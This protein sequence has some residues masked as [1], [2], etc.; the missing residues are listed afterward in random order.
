[1]R[2]KRACPVLRGPRRS[3]TLGLPGELVG[4]FKDAGEAW[5]R[6]PMVV[7]IHDFP[8]DADGRAVP[9][10]VYDVTTNHGLIYLGTSGDTAAFAAD[11]VATWWQTEGQRAMPPKTNSFY[12]QMRAAARVVTRVPG[13]SAC[14]Y[15][16]AIDSDSP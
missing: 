8:S 1:M 16:S 9:Y 3:N 12:W 10:G 5:V 13:R 2:G 7:N 15:K 14:K 6:E 11:A 4:D